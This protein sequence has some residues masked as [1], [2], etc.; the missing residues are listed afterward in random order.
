MTDKVDGSAVGSVIVSGSAVGS[1]IVSDSVHGVGHPRV[2]QVLLQIFVKTSVIMIM[3][4]PP[5]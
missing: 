4:S 3:V 1:V 5:A 2:L